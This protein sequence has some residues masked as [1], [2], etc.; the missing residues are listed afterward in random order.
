MKKFK[1]NPGFTFIELMMAIVMIGVMLSLTMSVVISTIRFHAFSN[2][3]RQNQQSGRDTLDSISRD[4][5]FGKLIQ[6][7]GNEA[8]ESVCILK[9]NEKQVVKYEIDNIYGIGIFKYTYPYATAEEYCNVPAGV[10]PTML[11]NPSKM[12]VKEFKVQKVRGAKVVANQDSS[13]VTI[14]LDFFTG[15]P[16]EQGFGNLACNSRDIYC[17]ELVYNTA[18]N[19]GG[20]N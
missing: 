13:S 2:T 10:Q 11:T 12:I 17:N 5:R 6:P 4:L 19:I 16:E 14:R 7:S 8:A 20:G 3:V 15:N 9:E 1:Q 18:V